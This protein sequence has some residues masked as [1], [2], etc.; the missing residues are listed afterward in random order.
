MA[1]CVEYLEMSEFDSQQE[2]VRKFFQFLG[3]NVV[4]GKTIHFS[5]YVWEY[6]SIY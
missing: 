5:L 4:W 3:Q 6:V 1:I 2:Y